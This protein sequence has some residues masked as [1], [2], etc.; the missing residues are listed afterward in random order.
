[1]YTLYKLR[2]FALESATW[3]IYFESALPQELC[4]L[5]ELAMFANS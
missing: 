3:Q 5:Q 2:L 1:M 4:Q